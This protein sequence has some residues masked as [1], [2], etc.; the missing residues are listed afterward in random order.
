MNSF[1]E[2]IFS[3]KY[4]SLLTLIY[5]VVFQDF[6][7]NFF[8]EYFN[9]SQIKVRYL[10]N[11]FKYSIKNNTKKTILIF[12]PSLYHYECTP[13]YAKYFIELG[14]NIDIIM[15]E[16]G[17]STFEIFNPLESESIR[18]FIYKDRAEAIKYGKILSLLSDKYYYILIETTEPLPEKIYINKEFL[19][20]NNSIFV[21]H[22]LDYIYKMNFSRYNLQNRIWSIGNFSTGLQVNPHYF[23]NL[24]FKDKNK[25]TKF[26]ITSSRHRSYEFIVSASKKLK[27]ENLEFQIIVVGKF[28]TFS[29]KNITEELKNNF[30]FR[31][32][33]SY[34]DLYKTVESADFIIINLDPKN[35]K[36]DE[37]LKTRVTGS[38]QLVYGFCKPA[39]I[40]KDF[41]KIYNL[42]E[43]NSL[44]KNGNFVNINIYIIEYFSCKYE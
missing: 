20:K 42:N 18:L 17:I 40:N 12:E 32:N 35:K 11:F 16:M 28:N 13:G 4:I 43:S 19:N 23:G 26:F 33:I 38:A 8:I 44:L 41:A 1:F 7:Y 22:H 29:D 5:I 2:T 9:V 30:I 6:I 31:Y 39:L 27:Q 14:F 15:H 36:D 10:K 37:F 34:I 21:F 24:R 25:I 3:F